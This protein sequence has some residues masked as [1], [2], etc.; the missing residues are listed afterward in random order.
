M[1]KYA[2]VVPRL[3]AAI[4]LH[5]V[6]PGSDFELTWGRGAEFGHIGLQDGRAEWHAVLNVP[7]GTRF[8][9]PLAELRRRFR[10]WHDP[11][12]ARLDATRADAV[13]HH[14]V[15]ELRTP[16]SHPLAVGLRNTAMRLPPRPGHHAHAPTAPQL[17]A[18]SGEPQPFSRSVH[19]TVISPET[20][21]SSR[22][23]AMLT[24]NSGRP[25]ASSSATTSD[26][27]R[28]RVAVAV[29]V[30]LATFL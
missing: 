21:S 1:R 3:A 22:W 4:G 5:T 9:D 26:T 18:A 19:T 8:A 16:L 17:G 7:A 15:N 29:T 6:D 11:I 23:M 28:P 14:D 30:P 27:G 12:P 24:G 10:T 13:L 25:P 2:D 20:A